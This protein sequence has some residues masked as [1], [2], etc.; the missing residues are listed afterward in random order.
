MPPADFAT[1][2]AIG[3]H[4]EWLLRDLLTARGAAVEMHQRN[5][6]AAGGGAAVAHLGTGT[7]HLPDFSVTWAQHPIGRFAVECKAKHPLKRGGFGWDAR[8]FD[9]AARWSE[10]SGQTVF[11]VVRD[12]GEPLPEVGATN[13]DEIYNWHVASTWKL[14]HSPNRSSDGQHNYW[15]AEDFTPLFL[16]LE[17]LG[18]IGAV[19][20]PIIPAGPGRAPLIL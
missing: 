14:A 17:D 15:P 11:Y 2:K 1:R 7:I 16:L 12:L 19:T 9:R 6:D 18:D 10:V 8:G 3:D 20:V 5:R 13:D 4:A